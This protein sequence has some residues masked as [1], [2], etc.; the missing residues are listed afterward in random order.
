MTEGGGFTSHQPQQREKA[1]KYRT[2]V[3]HPQLQSFKLTFILYFFVSPTN[4]APHHP[5]KFL[6]CV[7]LVGN[8]PIFSIFRSDF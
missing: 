1:H 8:K 3:W 2:R 7:N 4:F 5:G 6:L